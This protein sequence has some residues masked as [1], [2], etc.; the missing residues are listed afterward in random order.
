MR[1]LSPL[2]AGLLLGLLTSSLLAQD[3]AKKPPTEVAI[4]VEVTAETSE[5]AETGRLDLVF[6]WT[7]E[8]D[9]S[10]RFVVSCRLRFDGK[11]LLNRDHRP[12][13]PS[14]TWKAGQTQRYSVPVLVPIESLRDRRGEIE[15]EVA[16]FDTEHNFLVQTRGRIGSSNRYVV[17]GSFEIPSFSTIEKA[18]RR[19]ALLEKGRQ[20]AKSGDPRGAFSV[21]ETGFRLSDT[22][23]DKLLFRD[24]LLALGEFE[25][26]A[27]TATEEETVRRRIADERRR[28]LRQLSGRMYDR[29]R[30]HGALRI[31]EDIGGGLEEDA[32]QAVI[33]AVD[34]VKR[35]E[36]DRQDI[37]R[38]IREKISDEDKAEGQALFEKLGETKKCLE[39]AQKVSKKG[40]HA[41]ARY[42]LRK[43]RFAEDEALRSAAYRELE[44]VE[45]ALLAAIPDEE[46]RE[47]KA[48]LEHPAWSRT[49]TRTTHNFI[50]I[51]P[52]DFLGGIGAESR[53]RF[54]L[55]YVL[56][57]D[58][59][60]NVPNAGGDRITV[61]FKELWDFPGGVAGGRTI[62]IGSVRPKQKGYR[63]DTGLMYHELTHCIENVRP[64]FHG[65]TEGLANLGAL[66]CEEFLSVK[67]L[68]AGL[69]K[70][71][72]DAFRRY[73]LDRTLEYW[74]IPEYAPSCGFF[75]HFIDTYAKAGGGRHDWRPMRKFLREYSQAPVRDGREPQIVRAFAWYLT[76]A[77][78]EK[79]FDDLIRFRFPL[80]ESDR[81][82]VALELQHFSQKKIVDFDE[83]NAPADELQDFPNSVLPRDLAFREM[84][85]MSR[86][87]ASRD[88]VQR[89]AEEE[90]GIIF[91]WRAIGAFR[92]EGTDPDAG[93]FP[94]E[95]EI[96]FD[97]KYRSGSNL[98]SWRVPG[99]DPPLR[100]NATGWLRFDFPYQDNTA[101][102]AVT[103]VYVDKKTEASAF[104][105]GDDDVTLFIGDRMIGKYRGRG[106]NGSSRFWWRGPVATLPDAMRFEVSLAAGWNRVL[107]KIKNRHGPAGLSLAFVNPD[108]SPI[109]SLRSA[110]EA[111]EGAQA[112]TPAEASW[113]RRL[114]HRFDSKSFRSKLDVAVGSF[115]VARKH[116]EGR[117]SDGRVI[118]RPFDVRPGVRKDA[119]SN[120]LWLKSK[121]TKDIQ[122]F[123]LTIDLDMP[124]GRRPKLALTFM[125]EGKDDG[126]SGWTLI[127]HP[128][129]GDKLAARLERYD[130]LVYQCAPFEA[131]VDEKNPVPLRLTLRGELLDLQL[132]ELKLLEQRPIRPIEGRHRI[133]LSTW[134]GDTRIRGFE[135]ETP[136]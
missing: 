68:R 112:A 56:L 135:L 93:I 48:A 30:L 90:L 63:V 53:L 43:L 106:W 50:F 107:A 37:I 47:V 136:R 91:D 65:F 96:D 18:E 3:E 51:G 35:T 54:D 60:A 45:A 72:L 8:K 83:N 25:P 123:R 12:D 59:F 115:R 26:R 69:F 131:P 127:L 92:P 40:Q 38:R 67:R 132:G 70:P 98:C 86:S 78:G 36:K 58:L 110:S 94:P 133:G 21:F 118:W 82:A 55:A 126:L 52:K 114:R 7:P 121:F 108:T 95:Y 84:M 66:F 16:L 49:V 32:D 130:R 74:R 77:F 1:R 134:N 129:G 2:F 23:A 105:R 73:Y 6:A 75:C 117:N 19:D 97:K 81:R 46:A 102:Y 79:A 87:R 109:E 125:G 28:F 80:T 71:S 4:D 124:K 104:L 116:L 17:A 44:T 57:T 61:Y 119:P 99:D 76:R 31:I 22:D 113:K 39:R 9:Q 128:S 29:G 100:Q 11:T 120:L 10:R 85:K 42:L 27:M 101:I 111:P 41:L 20:R 34:D 122:D 14:R 64:K 13:P 103:W 15:I 5:L 88:E 62:D 89:F 24:A 33:G